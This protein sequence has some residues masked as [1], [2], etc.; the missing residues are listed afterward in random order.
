MFYREDDAYVA[1]LSVEE[2]QVLRQCMAELADLLSDRLDR[3]DPVVERLFPDIYRDDPAAAGELRRLTESDL[4]TAKMAQVGQVLADLPARGGEVRLDE[5]Q[6]DSW[7][8][9][10]TDLRLALGL[11]LDIQDDTDIESELD[12]AVLRS[13]TS[14]R[15]GQLSIYGYLSLLQQSLLEALLT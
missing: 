3:D 4:K 12:E 2:C 7:L 11:R 9:T 10:L 5:E 15:V 14:P 8:R 1:H 13:P 6:A